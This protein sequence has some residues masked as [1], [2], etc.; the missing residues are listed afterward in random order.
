MYPKFRHEAMQ[1]GHDAAVA[2][3]DG[4]IAESKE[5]AEMFQAVLERPPALRRAGQGGRKAR[6]TLPGAKRR[7][8]R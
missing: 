3:I 2:E 1:E 6:E 7:D 4:Q 8:C 5:H